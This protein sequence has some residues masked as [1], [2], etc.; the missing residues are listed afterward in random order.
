MV[1]A[2]LEQP[3]DAIQMHCLE[4]KELTYLTSDKSKIDINPPVKM[5]AG[6]A[7]LIHLFTDG[8]IDVWQRIA[9]GEKG[10]VQ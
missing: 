9:V 3:V 10:R 7:Y 2:E 4:D 1:R 5:K 8:T 6:E